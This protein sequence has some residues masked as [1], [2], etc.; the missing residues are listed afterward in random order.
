[1]LRLFNDNKRSRLFRQLQLTIILARISRLRTR[2][3][4]GKYAAI[5][6]PFNRV[7]P[8]EF[9]AIMIKCFVCQ[10]YSFCLNLNQEITKCH[11]RRR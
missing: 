5:H 2:W 6:Y 11:R 8:N 7:S 1:M 3:L 10:G 9:L 4:K